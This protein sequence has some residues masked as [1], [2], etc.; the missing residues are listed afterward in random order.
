MSISKDLNRERI[1][2]DGQS[3]SVSTSSAV[4]SSLILD[5]FLVNITIVVA[6]LSITI[7]ALA[8]I[9]ISILP[10]SIVPINYKPVPIVLINYKPVPIVPVPSSIYSAIVDK[11]AMFI[12]TEL[13]DQ[14][15]FQS[16]M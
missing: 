3:E 16:C 11:G 2:T 4:G 7:I 9:S 12:F 15:R 8:I 10:M 14:F 5:L 6:I 1:S 13:T